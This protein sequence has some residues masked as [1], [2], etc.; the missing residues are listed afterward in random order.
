MQRLPRGDLGGNDHDQQTDS[1]ALAGGSRRQHG[2]LCVDAG[3][4]DDVQL[5]GANLYNER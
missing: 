1:A 3:T 2:T 5:Y 4:G